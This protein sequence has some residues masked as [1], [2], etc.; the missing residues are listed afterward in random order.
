MAIS[1]PAQ[2]AP[3]PME[4]YFMPPHLAPPPGYLSLHNNAEPLPRAPSCHQ[5]SGKHR[6]TEESNDWQVQQPFPF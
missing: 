6:K 4:Q 3:A 2:P 5:A 1:S